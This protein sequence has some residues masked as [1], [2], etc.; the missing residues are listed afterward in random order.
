VRVFLGVAMLVMM[1]SFASAG[2]GIKWVEESII[3]EEGEEGCLTYYAYNPWD[4]DST[5]VIGLSGELTDVLTMQEAET[6]FVPAHTSSNES[7]PIKFCFEVPRV[8]ERDCWIGE[9]LICEQQCGVEQ[10]VYEGEVYLTSVPMA[11]GGGSSTAVAVSADLRI[12]VPCKVHGRDY[13]LV[14]LVLAIIALA[15]IVILLKRKYGKPKS[16]R[17]REEMKK[18]RA[19]MKGSKKTPKS[20]QSL[21]KKKKP[22]K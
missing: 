13:T 21:G 11:G 2:V 5:V 7:L 12:R 3:V 22:K 14:F 4:D 8:Y 10:K 16:E 17:L 9:S 15:V 19:E 18:L 6:K 20:T 1:A